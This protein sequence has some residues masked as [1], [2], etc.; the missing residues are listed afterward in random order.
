MKAATI[1][2]GATDFGAPQFS[3]DILW[4]TG[5]RA[6][7]P[8]WMIDAGNE[9]ALLVSP[10]EYE[11]AR[12]EARTDK[13]LNG[14][15]WPQNP[16][17]SS[18]EGIVAML[19]D[20]HITHLRV[21]ADFPYGTAKK[22]ERRFALRSESSLLYPERARKK[23]WEIDEMEKVQRAA[24][25]ALAKVMTFLSECTIRDTFVMREGD[26]VTSELLR[27]MIHQDLFAGGFHSLDTIVA[28]GPHAADPHAR[29]EGPIRA[30]EPLVIDIF[31]VS[32]AT[33]YYADMTRTFFKGEPLP[34]YQRMYEAVLRAEEAAEAEVRAGADGR[35]L[36]KMVERIFIESGYPTSIKEDSAQGFMHALG[37]GVGILLHEPPTIGPRGG[38]LEKGNVITVEP[39]LYYQGKE[40]AFPRCGIRIEDMLLVEKN[41]SRNLTR[42]PKKFEDIVGR[43]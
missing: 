42:F 19:Q 10:L 24:E 22:L 6:P 31:P 1:V 8:F 30:R 40:F 39:G 9:T 5:F 26:A 2:F 27:S 29:G 20:M 18:L 13:V 34:E 12:K 28:S 16:E 43:C 17:K 21:P 23:D 37:H 38:V 35:E 15:S 32:A 25:A 41:G 4:K 3:A 14:G 33:H 36:Q 7:D 11:R